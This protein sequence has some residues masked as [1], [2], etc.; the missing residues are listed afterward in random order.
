VTE[1]SASN[2]G[3][4]GDR[5]LV[6]R[7]EVLV[8]MDADRREIP[9]GSILLAGDAIARVGAD[10]EVAQWIAEDAAARSPRRIIDAHGCVVLPG[11]VN[12]HHHLFQSLTRAIGTGQG[13]SLFD[14]LRL[15][16]PIWAELN[17]EA[18]YISAKTALAD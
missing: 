15:L 5:L 2:A 1:P 11:L 10:A 4:T 3:V 14:W 17:A 6:R 16:Y 7:A 8:T 18:V 9:G 12:C 13:R